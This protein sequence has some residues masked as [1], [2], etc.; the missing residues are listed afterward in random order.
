MPLPTGHLAQK[1]GKMQRAAAASRATAWSTARHGAARVTA[2]ASFSGGGG[3]VAGAA[4]PLRVRGG[5]LMSLPLLSG[6][7]AVTARVAAAEAPLPADDAD[8]AAGRERGALAETA[9][10]GAM[11]VAWYLLNIYFNIFNK[12][13]CTYIFFP[14]FVNF[15][16]LLDMFFFVSNLFMADLVG[17]HGLQVLKS[18]P[19]PY[20]ITTFQFA[21]G[22]FFITLMWLLN[23]HP[24][25]RLSLGQVTH[26][27]CQKKL[28]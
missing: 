17:I 14:Q 5:Q 22:S 13:V 24:K 18:V 6:G 11:I 2:S 27:S 15:L 28:E 26:C 1:P 19:F 4:L 8:A 7:R 16:L 9:Q 3:I 25:P 23:L 20:T 21:S 10:L 12:L